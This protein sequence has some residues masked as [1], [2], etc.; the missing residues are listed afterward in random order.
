MH[1]FIL[2]CS[3][4]QKQ[5]CSYQSDKCW[6]TEVPDHTLPV[7]PFLTQEAACQQGSVVKQCGAALTCER[8][9]RELAIE[10]DGMFYFDS[11]DNGEGIQGTTKIVRDTCFL[12]IQM[13]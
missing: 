4:H 5:P 1:A 11:R 8:G 6:S 3:I 13:K 2:T 7:L 9:E 10:S 12:A